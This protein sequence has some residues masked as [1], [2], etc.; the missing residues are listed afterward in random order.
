MSMVSA[1]IRNENRS[2]TRTILVV[3]DDSDL[4]EILQYNLQCA[5]HRVVP[6][7][8]A[9]AAV[10]QAAAHQPDLVLLDLMLPDA[11]GWAVCQFLRS[12]R[13]LQKTPVIVLTARTDPEDVVQA[14]TFRLAGFLTK[15]CSAEEIVR[16]VDEVLSEPQ[17]LL[18]GDELQREPTSAENARRTFQLLQLAIKL[19]SERPLMDSDLGSLWLRPKK[20]SRRQK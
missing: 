19:E 16:L 2:P 3:E 4:N 18:P 12:Q 11:D 7:Y 13:H 14:R 9:S 6:V 15:P 5:G 10:S 20:R 17:A 8:E 1:P